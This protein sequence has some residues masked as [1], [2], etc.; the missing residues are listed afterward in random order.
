[1]RG[2]CVMQRFRP[3]CGWS[4]EVSALCL[5]TGVLVCDVLSLGHRFLNQSQRGSGHAAP[6]YG[7]LACCTFKLK[8]LEKRQVQ[9]AS[10]TLP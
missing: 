9:K 10:L 7:T 3:V 2:W 6:R 1:M 8:E 4:P 5:F